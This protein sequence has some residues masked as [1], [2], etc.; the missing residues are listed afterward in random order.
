MIVAVIMIIVAASPL[1][2]SFIFQVFSAVIPFMTASMEAAQ[3]LKLLSLHWFLTV[4]LW[5]FILVFNIY[6]LS[7]MTSMVSF[8]CNSIM[9]KGVP[10]L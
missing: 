10:N 1:I 7:S 2:I 4:W 5:L 8:K 6:N 3:I 9:W